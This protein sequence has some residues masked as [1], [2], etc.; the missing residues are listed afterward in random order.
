MPSSGSGSGMD[1]DDNSTPFVTRFIPVP[2]GQM[3]NMARL[4]MGA[5]VGDTYMVYIIANNILGNS[6]A[7]YTSFSELLIPTYF[8]MHN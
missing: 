3:V 1:S 6:T 7:A 8:S 4:T 5:R 2:R